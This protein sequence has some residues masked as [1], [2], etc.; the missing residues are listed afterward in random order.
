M[1]GVETSRPFVALHDVLV[2]KGDRR[3]AGF[4]AC[5]LELRDDGLGREAHARGRATMRAW[6]EV[7]DEQ[8]SAGSERSRE[9]PRVLAT[10]REVVPHVHDEDAV[11]ATGR[12][13][14]GR[15]RGLDRAQVAELL[16]RRR[17]SR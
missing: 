15:R 4:E 6:A 12:Q 1:N 5:A 7:H 9:A 11:D 14:R 2:G 3:H 10:I 17:G 13:G 8:S 16:T